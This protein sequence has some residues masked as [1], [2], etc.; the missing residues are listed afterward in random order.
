MSGI[1]AEQ[2]ISRAKENYKERVGYVSEIYQHV[3][4]YMIKERPDEAKKE[5]TNEYEK[6]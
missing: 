4:H 3:R 6:N 5:W 2:D 1:G